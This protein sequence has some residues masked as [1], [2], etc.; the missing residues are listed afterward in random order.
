MQYQ[1]LYSKRFVRQY[2]K[3][4][5]S[6][7]KR[8]LLALDEVVIRLEHGENLPPKNHNHR[9]VGNAADFYECHVLPDW[10]LV[11]RIYGGILVLELI[12]TGTHSELFK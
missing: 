6:G 3:L 10:L 1:L 8:A 9:L 12:A 7:N 11:Y 5:R 2:R 4:S